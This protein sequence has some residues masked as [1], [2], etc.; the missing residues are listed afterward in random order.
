MLQMQGEEELLIEAAKMEQ[1]LYDELNSLTMNV[2]DPEKETEVREELKEKLGRYNNI[3]VKK[4]KIIK[5]TNDM[6]TSLKL[7]LAAVKHDA[8]MMTEIKENQVIELEEGRDEREN[9][10][11]TNAKLERAIIDLVKELETVR[12]TN[13]APNKDNS[14]LKAQLQV[15]DGLIKG[16]KEVLGSRDDVTVLSS[17]RQDDDASSHKCQACNSN[18]RKSDDLENHI[19]AK[20]TEK[21]CVYCETVFSSESFLIKHHKVCINNVGLAKS[22]CSNCNK[23]FTDNGLKRHQQNCHGASKKFDCPECGMI[24][25]SS[26][27]VKTHRDVEHEY[28]PVKSRVVCRHWRR[29][30][31][32]KGDRCG[33]SH[34]GKQ[35]SNEKESTSRTTTK[36]PECSNGP[37]CDW[38]ARGCCS[39]FHPRVGVQKPWVKRDRQDSRSQNNFSSRQEKRSGPNAD[40]NKAGKQSNRPTCKYDG[41]CDRIPNCPDMHYQ[42]DFPQ[43]QGRRN[44]MTRRNQNQRRN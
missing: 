26:K 30:N 23:N 38:L 3:M 37:S 15:K 7:S 5:E 34:V 41:R 36:V 29:G 25:E 40:Q 42:E 18:F 27:D 32:L 14:D 10:S 1:D 28:V 44:P 21:S 8:A 33:F 20:H 16:L 19:D 17:S 6:I 22:I 9:L 39:Y 31:C 35:S 2:I 13:G 24:L 11:K 4:N 43:F 12:V